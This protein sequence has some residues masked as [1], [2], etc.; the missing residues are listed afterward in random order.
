[1]DFV[2]ADGNHLAVEISR[3]VRDLVG[4]Q[5]GDGITSFSD[6]TSWSRCKR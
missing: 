4:R 6:D 1:M 2:M 3:R 5:F